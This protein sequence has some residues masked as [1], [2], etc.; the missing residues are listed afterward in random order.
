MRAFVRSYLDPGDRLGEVLFGLIMVLTITLTTELALEDGRAGARELLIAAI[1]CNVAWGIIDGGMYVMGAMLERARR[2]NAILAV[3]GAPDEATALAIVE[4]ALEGTLVALQPDEERRR[5]YRQV[6]EMALRATPAPTRLQREDLLGGAACLL[7]VVLSVVPVV[8][9]F[10]LIR[11]PWLALRVSNALLVVL[12][13]VTGYEWGR[14]ANTS[15]WLAGLIY[16]AV[17]LVLVG[18]AIALGG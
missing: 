11:D 4:D 2:A 9:P 13:F 18:V 7:L 17:G 14:H 6:R 5:L 16:M 10:L 15:R 1:G 3:K 12:L 8:L